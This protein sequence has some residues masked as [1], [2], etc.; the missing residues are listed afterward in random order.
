MHKRSK[1]GL[2][3]GI[4]LYWECHCQ[5]LFLSEKILDIQKVNLQSLEPWGFGSFVHFA[6]L[7]SSFRDSFLSH[8]I[9]KLHKVLSEKKRSCP[10]MQ[11]VIPHDP[12][13]F[14]RLD[15]SRPYCNGSPSLSAYKKKNIY[16]FLSHL[17]ESASF[18]FML[19][20]WWFTVIPW[21]CNGSQSISAYRNKHIEFPLTPLWEC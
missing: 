6:N 14:E 7:K 8:L 4:F 13:T 21:P 12:M 1:I 2:W 17:C 10:I 11:A 5:R 9:K 15:R 3:R 18:T 16:S 20:L 19:Q